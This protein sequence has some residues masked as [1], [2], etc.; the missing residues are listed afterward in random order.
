MESAKLLAVRAKNLKTYSRA[1][2]PCVLTYT[3]PKVSCVLLRAHIPTC[4]ACS[5]VHAATCLECIGTL[6]VIMSG[7]LMIH[8]S[9]WLAS[10]RAHA[11]TYFVSL[12]SHGLRDYVITCQHT[13]PP[14]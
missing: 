11:P 1:N 9:M 13:F 5:R 12:L 3:C 7:M 4:F 14:Q 2:V 6:H 8:V 10:S